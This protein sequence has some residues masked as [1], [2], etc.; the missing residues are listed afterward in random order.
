MACWRDKTGSTWFC[1]SRTRRTISCSASM[2]LAVVNWRAGWLCERSTIWNSPDGKT[3]VKVAA[4][5]G[6]SH[7]AHAAAEPVADQCPFIDDSLALEV[8]VAGKSQRLA[9][10]VEGVDGF[11]LM[12]KPLTRGA[13]DGFGLVAEVGGELAM[14]RH[15]IGWRMNLF[16]VARGVRGDL[17]RLFSGAPGPLQILT[18]LLAAR[19]GCV[20]VL[21]RV[22]L[23][24]RS[25]AAANGD[26]VTELAKPVSQLRLIDGGGKLL[27]CEKA[28]RL[29]GAGLAVVAL[30]DIEDDGMGMKLR[31][32]VTIDRAGGVMLEFGSNE[33]GRGFGRMVSANAGLRV[34]FQ[35][36]PAPRERSR[37]G[38]RAR[39]R[40]RPRAR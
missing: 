18:N 35:A 23:D 32:N 20:K 40:R 5:L 14:R 1:P 30:G 12:L 17:G 26:L 21:L 33:F 39:C 2:V 36:A 24:F 15:D 29:D 8:L 37:D 6:I 16:A 31:R 25:A 4:Y 9:H 11:L 7:L 3:G 19:A 10:A 13:N 28:L 38:P 27:R 34:A 22:A